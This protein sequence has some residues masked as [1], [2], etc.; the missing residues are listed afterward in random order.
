MNESM[1]QI[2]NWTFTEGKKQDNHG[3]SVSIPDGFAVL[4]TVENRLF[5]AVPKEY[6]DGW[7]SA[8]VVLLPGQELPGVVQREDWLFHPYAREGMAETVGQNMA[9]MLTRAMNTV[10]DIL[11]VAFSDL[12]AYI[13]VQDTTENSYSYQC[14]VMT[15]GR[16]QM[17]PSS[18]K[19]QKVICRMSP[20]WNRRQYLTIFRK[21][22]SA[23]LKRLSNA[24]IWNMRLP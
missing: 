8:P 14:V 24:P 23:P 11:S 9:R 19:K 1:E 3:W 6:E 13:L 5:M 17:L 18:S 4:D 15:V 2:Y 7:Q 20:C 12:C 16:M 22:D 10:P 21:A